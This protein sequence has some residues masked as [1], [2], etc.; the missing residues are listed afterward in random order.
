VKRS[1][2]AQSRHNV[3]Q[4][5]KQTKNFIVVLTPGS[6]DKQ[7]M[8]SPAGGAFDVICEVK[9]PLAETPCDCNMVQVIKILCLLFSR[10][11]QPRNKASAM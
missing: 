3:L 8:N 7:L 10:K 4:T 11:S 5:I 1:N 2:D 9:A 6:L